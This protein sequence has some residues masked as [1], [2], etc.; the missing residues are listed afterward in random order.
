M[1]VTD[2]GGD[3]FYAQL[4]GFLTDEYGEKSG[5]IRYNHAGFQ[6]V[7][8][9]RSVIFFS[10]PD[11]TTFISDLNARKKFLRIFFITNLPAGT[12]SSVVKIYFF[13]KILC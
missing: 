6:A 4:R 12:L 2:V 11:P 7:L 10:D 13:A 3:I 1:S 8:G 9:I 5:V